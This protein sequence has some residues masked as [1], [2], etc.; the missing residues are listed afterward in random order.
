MGKNF[1]AIIR[2]DS[3]RAVNFL[4]IF[5]RLEVNIESPMAEMARLPGVDEP[6]QV[7]KLDLDLITDEER[8]RLARKLSR[9]FGLTVEEID[10]NIDAYGVPIFGEDCTIVI[11][12]P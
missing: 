7:Y 11:E 1:K 8:G 12:N 9:Q 6:V 4:E 2:H 5:G 3:D 10:A